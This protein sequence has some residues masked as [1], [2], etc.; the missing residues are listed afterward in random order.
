MSC[1]GVASFWPW[2]KYT[3]PTIVLSSKSF[4]LFE[5][6]PNC[7]QTQWLRF[8][9]RL[10]NASLR[11]SKAQL[12]VFYEELDVP[13]VLFNDVLDHVLRIDCVFRQVQGHLLLISVSGSGKYVSSSPISC[14]NVSAT[15]NIPDHSFMV[16]RLDE[17]SQY[18]P[19][20]SLKQIYRRRFR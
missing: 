7:S 19:D 9:L 10:R 5:P 8:T 14:Q 11:T 17:W 13:L 15:Y 12:H 3:V 20:Q 18:L 1:R 2:N 16:R 4:R 6:M